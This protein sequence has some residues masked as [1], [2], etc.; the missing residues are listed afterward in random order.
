MSTTNQ[1]RNWWAKM[2][3]QPQRRPE[4]AENQ[5]DLLH[6]ARRSSS[7]IHS[8]HS[9]NVAETGRWNILYNTRLVNP[10]TI[11]RKAR[12]DAFSCLMF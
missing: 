11:A 7:L 12:V 5:A 10:K 6:L 4:N 3:H 2:P 1:K 9:F 8:P